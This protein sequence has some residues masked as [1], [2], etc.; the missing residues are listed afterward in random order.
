[1]RILR[2]S[3]LTGN[4]NTM[5]INVTDEQFTKYLGSNECIQNVLPDLSVDEREFLISGITPDE[6]DNTFSFTAIS[7]DAE[8]A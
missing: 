8:E 3:V 5:D 4:V 2:K 1:M 6:W 7:L